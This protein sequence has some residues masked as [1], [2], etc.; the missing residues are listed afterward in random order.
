MIGADGEVRAA[1]VK[2]TNKGR[3]STLWRPIQHLYSLEV[4]CLQEEE[5][6]QENK[7]EIQDESLLQSAQEEPLQLEPGNNFL[8]KQ[9]RN[10][11]TKE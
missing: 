8:L 9:S 7:V 2:V 10:H 3:S 11:K 1:L 6:T 5:A 4:R